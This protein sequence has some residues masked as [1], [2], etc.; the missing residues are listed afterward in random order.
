MRGLLGDEE[1]GRGIG[2]KK[3]TLDLLIRKE[4]GVIHEYWMQDLSRKGWNIDIMS[5]YYRTIEKIV[6]ILEMERE[7]SWP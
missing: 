4:G 6:V 7:G 1:R 5:V 2:N 3:R